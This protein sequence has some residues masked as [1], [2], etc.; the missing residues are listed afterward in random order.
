MFLAQT[1]QWVDK[2]VHKL[3]HI[4]SAHMFVSAEISLTTS[5]G[6]TIVSLQSHTVAAQLPYNRCS[7]VLPVGSPSAS[8]ALL[9]HSNVDETLLFTSCRSLTFMLPELTETKLVLGTSDLQV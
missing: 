3:H 9:F 8:Q 5:S 2:I 4:K 1:L 7:P 6:T